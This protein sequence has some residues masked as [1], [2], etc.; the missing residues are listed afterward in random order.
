MHVNV[1]VVVVLTGTGAS[2]RCT[3]ADATDG[4]A[5]AASAPAMMKNFFMVVPLRGVWLFGWL[6]PGLLPALPPRA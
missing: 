1:A 5:S 6:K 2:Q 4:T 3:S